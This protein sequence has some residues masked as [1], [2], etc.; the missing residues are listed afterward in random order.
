MNPQEVFTRIY[1]ERAWGD[2]ESASGAGSSLME[3]RVVRDL[4]PGLLASLGCRSLLD[5][6]CGDFNWM[7][8]VALDGIHYTG[9]DIVE[10]LIA[11]N[12]ELYGGAHRSF[13]VMN[14]LTGPLPRADVVLCRDC[15]GH[16]SREDC[17]RALA[18]IKA[19]GSTYLLSTTYPV[20]SRARALNTSIKTG[21]WYAINLEAA[22][23][24]LPAPVQLF[25][26]GCGVADF[27]DK[28]LGLWRIDTIPD[29]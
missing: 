3:T 12:R 7:R 23:F 2:G 16:L 26:E 19:S 21:Q 24:R 10:P 5:L 15:L 18:S 4:L 27:E 22:P 29:Y 14:L 20:V 13:E 1:T 25:N 6:P 28:S 8:H 9:A 11:R 17:R